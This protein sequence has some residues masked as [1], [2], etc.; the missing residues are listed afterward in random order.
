MEHQ[1]RHDHLNV[2]SNDPVVIPDGD[3]NDSDDNLY[4]DRTFTNQLIRVS[5]DCKD[6]DYA[7]GHLGMERFF[8][9]RTSFLNF[10]DL[11]STRNFSSCL[12]LN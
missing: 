12:R 9:K 3:S 6:I 1:T 7:R 11:V 10:S 4:V 2:N 5:N 8:I